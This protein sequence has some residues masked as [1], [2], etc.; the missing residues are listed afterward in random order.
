MTDFDK[1]REAAEEIKLDD[2]QKQRI[3]EACKGKKRRRINYTAVAG[4]AAALIVTVVVFSPGF[5]MKAKEADSAV[6]EAAVEDYHAADQEMQVILSD[7]A[8]SQ[9]SAES[10]NGSAD[11][12]YAYTAGVCTDIIFE[13]GGFRSI[14]SIIPQSFINLVDRDEYDLWVS[15]VSAENG[16]AIVQFK[17]Y[18]GISQEAFDEANKSYAKYISGLYGVMPLYCTTVEENE[19][20]EIFRTDLIYSSDREA[21][22]EYYRAF[23]EFP[24]GTVHSSPAEIIVPEE[25]YK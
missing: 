18:F 17:D 21:V 1:L 4:I 12:K 19:K 2:L 3:L 22:D 25:Y 5:L 9:H 24:E 11:N 7:G 14:Y 6:N 15:D 23:T 10:G 16:M 8:Y 20:Y 13:A